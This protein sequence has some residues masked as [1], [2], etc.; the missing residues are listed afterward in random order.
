MFGSSVIVSLRLLVSSSRFLRGMAKPTPSEIAFMKDF[1]RFLQ[2]QPNTNDS[3]ILDLERPNNPEWIEEHELLFR[4]SLEI[5]GG[6]IFRQG[7]DAA[8]SISDFIFQMSDFR[9]QIFSI[10]EFQISDIE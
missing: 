4:K 1:V 2:T 9:F 6:C 7:L 10:S 3:V 8:T 5:S